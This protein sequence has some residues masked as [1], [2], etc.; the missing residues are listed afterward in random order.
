MVEFVYFKF[1]WEVYLK[2]E[3]LL[4][5][6]GLVINNFGVCEFFDC[7]VEVVFLFLGWVMEEWEVKLNEDKFVGFVFKIYVNMD[8]NYWDCIVFLW[9]CFGC[10]ECNINYLYVW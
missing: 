2:G 5:F 10:F 9:V 7:F 3:F 1:D 6:F 8:F 4:V